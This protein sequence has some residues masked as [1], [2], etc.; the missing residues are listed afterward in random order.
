MVMVKILIHIIS[1]DRLK[2]IF[3]SV[4]KKVQQQAFLSRI[5]LKWS[6]IELLSKQQ[7]LGHI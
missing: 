4:Q 6:I 2:K 3:S 5:I 7:P 1:I